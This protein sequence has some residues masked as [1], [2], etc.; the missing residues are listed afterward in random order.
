MSYS[1]ENVLAEETV[2]RMPEAFAKI[3]CFI[4]SAWTGLKIVRKTMISGLTHYEDACTECDANYAYTPFTCTEMNGIENS[5][6]NIGVTRKQTDDIITMISSNRNTKYHFNQSFGSVYTEALLESV[7]M[8]EKSDENE[9][10]P[11]CLDFPESQK[12]LK[13]SHIVCE[14]CYEKM[15]KERCPVCRCFFEWNG[16][17]ERFLF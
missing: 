3:Y 10:C 15:N 17:V 2:K 11:I 14:S 12:E 1:D 7:Q 6:K 4:C 5:L 8:R 9:K 13:C 16:D